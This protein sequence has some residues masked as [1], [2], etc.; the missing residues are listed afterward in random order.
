M[1]FGKQNNNGYNGNNNNSE[2]KYVGGF[3]FKQSKNGVQYISLSING[4]NYVAFENNKKT[5]NKSP[6]WV[7]MESGN[8]NQGTKTYNNNYNQGNN[9]GY[10]GN[11]NY[12]DNNNGNFNN[13]GNYNAS[14]NNS[15]F[16]NNGGFFP[17][18]GSQEQQNPSYSM[19]DN[20][21]ILSF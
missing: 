4:K 6:D 18:S 14:D 9:N 8:S 10:N 17:Q 7:I 21:D 5:S 12:N 11:N 3:W 19:N 20:D 1:G 15:N 16:Q 2:S 13:N